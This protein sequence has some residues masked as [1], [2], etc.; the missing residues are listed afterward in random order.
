MVRITRQSLANGAAGAWRKKYPEGPLPQAI[1]GAAL[2]E[3][4]PTP[5]PDDVDRVIGNRSGTRVEACS[6]CG[7]TP[8]AVVRISD[9]ADDYDE[10]SLC[11]CFRC[12]WEA[13][14]MVY[15]QG[16]RVGCVDMAGGE[17]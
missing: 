15:D 11:L 9:G 1:I 3:L 8:E 5:S 10:Q 12:L 4:G 13:A 7:E 6:Q 14:M 2:A 17:R 16:K